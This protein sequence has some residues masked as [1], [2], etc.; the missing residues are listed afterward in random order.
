[1]CLGWK[2]TRLFNNGVILLIIYWVWHLLFFV[3]PF[4]RA[5]LG[6]YEQIT[7]PFMGVIFFP[8]IMLIYTL[9]YAI[10]HLNRRH[11]MESPDSQVPK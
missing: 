6:S 10:T 4:Y 9:S 5:E 8:I 7:V 11:E 1:M 3:Q 2:R